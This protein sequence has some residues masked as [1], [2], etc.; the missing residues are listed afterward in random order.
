MENSDPFNEKKLK[1]LR[2]LIYLIPVA[3]CLPAF[4]TLYT[5]DSNRKERAIGRLSITLGISW[6][7][8]YSLL[9]AGTLQTSELWT[10]RLLYLNC[11]LTSGYFLAC[12]GL[13]LCLWQGYS[14]RLPEIDR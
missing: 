13:M 11:L 14:W 6:L 1:K 10:I 7:L 5:R 3:G 12:L 9:W 4:W 2:L 8:S